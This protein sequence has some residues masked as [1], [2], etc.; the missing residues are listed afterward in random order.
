V[1]Q[2]KWRF[3]S[4]HGEINRR[5]ILD[6][7][8]RL[9][10]RDGVSPGADCQTI[11]SILATPGTQVAWLDEPQRELQTKTYWPNPM[12]RVYIPKSSGSQRPL[13]IPTVKDQVAQMAM[14]LVLMPIF[15]A[16]FHPCSF[17]FRP[18]RNAYQALDTIVEALR[19]GQGTPQVGVIL[20]LQASL[21]LRVS[22]DLQNHCVLAHI[23]G[24]LPPCVH[25]A[26][27]FSSSP[28]WLDARGFRTRQPP[29]KSP[30][31]AP[32]RWT[33]RPCGAR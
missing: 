29:R 9:V 13:G 33:P 17:D 16:D 12:R 24:Y 28:C 15:E 10:A 19:S 18:E 26:S 25:V 11:G 22:L 2:L 14:Y 8:L 23:H 32:A 3:W 5:D 1:G 7:A 20:S 6:R 31:V 21:Y 4:L 27:S 30:W